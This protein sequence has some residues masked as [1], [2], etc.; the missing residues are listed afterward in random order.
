VWHLEISAATV[1]RA[2]PTARL[3]APRV[4]GG[5]VL[6]VLEFDD[7][8]Q[9]R[10]VAS[11]GT[12]LA[13]AAAE[14]R[15]AEDEPEE[16]AKAIAAALAPIEPRWNA[17]RSTSQSQS[18]HSCAALRSDSSLRILVSSLLD[19]VIAHF[20]ADCVSGD[21]DRRHRVGAQSAT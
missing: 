20:F 1:K 16:L 5:P 17:R 13:A 7:A 14:E 18:N 10:T 15:L 2:N 3:S 11:N 6:A 8:P 19:P 9:L 4:A 21:G 12:A